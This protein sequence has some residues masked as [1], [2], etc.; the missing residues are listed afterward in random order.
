LSKSHPPSEFP[1]ER[2][3][4]LQVADLLA[5]PSESERDCHILVQVKGG[6]LGQVISLQG[7][8]LVFGR[9]RG[10]D[11]FVPDQGVSRRH[12][13]VFFEAG[14]YFV[15]DLASA[16]GTFV[17]GERI[18]RRLLEDGDVFQIAAGVAYRYS[19]TDSNQVAVLQHLYD[20]SVR[21]ALTGAYNREYFDQRMTAELAYSRRHN[22]ELS[23]VMLDLDHFKRI[24]DTWGHLAGDAVLVRMAGAVR[25]WLR[26]EDVFCR[27]GGEE[28]AVI[29]RT[30]GL[31]AAAH[32]A[33]RIRASVEALAI[34]HDGHAIRITLS[35]GCAALTECAGDTPD[36]LVAI[37][38]RRL[39]AA[40]H[41]GRN[42]VVSTG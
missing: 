3:A 39:Y 30:T 11:V 25:G 27:Y 42:R 37:A 34:E 9:V 36:Q 16:N 32:V 1:E 41:G 40:K 31:A 38:D 20:A 5:T 7:G 24:N 33:E 18:T 21:D 28:F 15:E 23:L 10:V 12:A 35:S 22:V 19:Q 8:E 6:S 4:V 14:R 26:V 17:G 29:L 13:R 2:T